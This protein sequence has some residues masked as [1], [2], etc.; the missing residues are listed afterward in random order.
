MGC[1][2]LLTSGAEHALSQ[3]RK[4]KEKRGKKKGG[5]REPNESRRV[6]MSFGL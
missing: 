1:F 2:E 4:R 6:G 5:L 3:E